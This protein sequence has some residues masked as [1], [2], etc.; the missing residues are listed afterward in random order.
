MESVHLTDTAVDMWTSPFTNEITASDKV[1]CVT[2]SCKFV[3]CIMS[4]NVLEMMAY[5]VDKLRLENK[6]TEEKNKLLRYTAYRC[7]LTILELKGLGKGNRY[8]LPSCVVEAIRT[9]YPSPTDR[10]VGFK[11]GTDFDYSNLKCF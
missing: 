10:Y 1:E 5:G 9:R 4:E 2:E 6:S 7:F 11:D 3:H 8:E